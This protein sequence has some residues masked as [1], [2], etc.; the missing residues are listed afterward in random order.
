M[1]TTPIVVS[2]ILAL[3]VGCSTRPAE[4]EA[5]TEAVVRTYPENYQ[6][7][8]RRLSNAARRCMTGNLSA[9]ASLDVDA[10]LYSEL[11]YGEITQSLVN[12]G[13]RNYYWSA[14][15][16]KVDEGARL[17]M[18]AGN[19]LGADAIIRKSLRWAEGDDRC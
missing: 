10:Q 3:T 11:G 2:A 16:E 19:T 7:V 13:V 15:I 4:L 6:E 1:R 9:Y 18:N 5:K 17:T 12:L 14:K 8:F